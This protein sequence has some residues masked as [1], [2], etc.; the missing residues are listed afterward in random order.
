[1]EMTMAT[2]IVADP[3]KNNPFDKH[4]SG[5]DDDS[6]NKN[7]QPDKAEIPTATPSKAPPSVKNPKGAEEEGG[8]GCD[9]GDDDANIKHDDS[10]DDKSSSESESDSDDD[11]SV[12]SRGI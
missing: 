3:P 4:E 6:S 8:D 5:K 9:D 10:G 2:M 1:M 12:G 11:L 7:S